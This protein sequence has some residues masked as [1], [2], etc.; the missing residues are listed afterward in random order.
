MN[1]LFARKKKKIFKEK[2]VQKEEPWVGFGKTMLPSTQIC[3]GQGFQAP[4]SQQL[5]GRLKTV[6]QETTFADSLSH[7]NS[8]QNSSD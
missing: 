6:C 8:S 4:Q 3:L 1:R 7:C 2:N 5:S